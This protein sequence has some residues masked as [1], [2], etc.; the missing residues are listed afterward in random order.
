MELN[1]S[2]HLYGH[3][4]HAMGIR[5]FLMLLF[6]FVLTTLEAQGDTSPDFMR[7]IGKIYVVAAVCL[8]ILLAVLGYLVWLD[9]KITNIEKRQNHE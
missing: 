1:K 5:S 8:V 7:S 3:F 9:R 6:V 4:R 2:F